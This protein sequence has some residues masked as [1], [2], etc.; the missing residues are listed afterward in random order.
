MTQTDETF[1]AFQDGRRVA[2][3][4]LADVALALGRILA[5][6]PDAS[7]L[8]FRDRTGAV[9]DLDLRGSAADILS[10]LA[11]SHPDLMPPDAPEQDAAARGRGRPRLGVVP[12]E[13]TLL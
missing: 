10:R 7:M 4:P 8:V 12:R 1:T 2:R 13:V 6:R 11:Q 9:I 5:A 3:G